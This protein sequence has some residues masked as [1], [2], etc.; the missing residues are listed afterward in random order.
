MS[1]ARLSGGSRDGLPAFRAQRRGPRLA[2]LGLLASRRGK[3]SA[4]VRTA[5]PAGHLLVV[6]LRHRVGNRARTQA[7]GGVAATDGALAE[8]DLRGVA[9]R[10]GF[11]E[12]RENLVVG[13]GGIDG[14]GAHGVDPLRCGVV[15]VRHVKR[16]KNM[17]NFE[18]RL[19]EFEGIQRA[20]VQ[21]I[22]QNIEQNRP[23]LRS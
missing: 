16:A 18:S 23:T 7:A 11:L 13:D 15:R 22:R 19:D 5:D 12:Q 20:D 9:R 21:V 10:F 2:G 8:S 6:H 3:G 1:P 17:R 14:R 4:T